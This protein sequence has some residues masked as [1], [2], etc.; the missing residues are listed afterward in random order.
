[1]EVF[2]M[3]KVIAVLVTLFFGYLGTTIGDAWMNWPQLGPIAAIATMGVLILNE[4]ER[5][6]D[7]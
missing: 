3:S 6:K 2:I 5:Q 4:I 1:M 7:E